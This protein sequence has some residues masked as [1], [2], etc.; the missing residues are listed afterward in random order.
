MGYGFGENIE[1]IPKTLVKVGRFDG[2]LE[3]AVEKFR[4]PLTN[5]KLGLGN[6]IKYATFRQG[7]EPYL[8]MVSQQKDRILTPAGYNVI[9]T[10]TS[11]LDSRNKQVADQFEKETGINLNVNVMEQLIRQSQ[12]IGMS[13]Q[14][15]E[16]D[17][18]AAMA[19][20]RGQK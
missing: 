9:L 10:V 17:P 3:D 1:R 11:Y 2:S 20:L 15:F 12:I 6:T 8:L 16:K 7:E 5:V 4:E 13:F 18:A 14:L 19:V